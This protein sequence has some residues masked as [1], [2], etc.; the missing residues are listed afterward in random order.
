MSKYL[1]LLETEKADFVNDGWLIQ[2]RPVHKCRV[3]GW[4]A[5]IFHSI[6]FGDRWQCNCGQRWRWSLFLE[7]SF[8]KKV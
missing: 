4:F 1:H 7:E 8:W 6:R 5:R 3:P 2:D